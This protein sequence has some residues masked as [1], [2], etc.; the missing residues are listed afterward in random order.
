MCVSLR[1]AR[2]GDPKHLSKGGR[3]KPWKGAVVVR[4]LG[5]LVFGCE[6]HGLIPQQCLTG[7]SS[8]L[9]M[10]LPMLTVAQGLFLSARED[11]TCKRWDRQMNGWWARINSGMKGDMW[12]K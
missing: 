2:P 5:R 9:D 6:A 1:H 12:Q 8:V 4:W 3:G 11:Q 10:Y 7:I